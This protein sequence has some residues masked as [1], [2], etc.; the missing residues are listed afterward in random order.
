VKTATL[1]QR[2]ENCYTGPEKWDMLYWVREVKTTIFGQRSENCY[3][4]FRE[5]KTAI[6][7]S[8]K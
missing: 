8:D 6:L 1:G 7:G 3:I 5:V 2:S 4:G